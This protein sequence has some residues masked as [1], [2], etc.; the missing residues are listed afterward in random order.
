MSIAN[1]H[2]LHH[3]TNSTSEAPSSISRE[4]VLRTVS[5][6]VSVNVKG[7]QMSASWV[8]REKE[9]GKVIM[10]TFDSRK[11]TALNTSKYEAVPILKY[12][13]ELNQASKTT[14]EQ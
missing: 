9:T 10:E 2:P 4:S 12:L 11:V 14:K 6:E 7:K 5:C 13:Q 1:M 8:I 3:E